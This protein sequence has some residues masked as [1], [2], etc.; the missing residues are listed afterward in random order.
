M[1]HAANVRLFVLCQALTM[2]VPA[3]VIFAGGI[4]G[5]KLAPEEIDD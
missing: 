1:P 4:I 2:S 5:R 3:F